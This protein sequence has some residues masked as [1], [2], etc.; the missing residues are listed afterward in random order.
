MAGGERLR[1]QALFRPEAEAL[2]DFLLYMIVTACIYSAPVIGLVFL[3]RRRIQRRIAS[4]LL[5]LAFACATAFSLWRMEWFDVW[6][7]GVPPVSYML[8]A[9]SP[10]LTVFGVLGWITGSLIVRRSQLTTRES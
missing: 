8:A 5:A 3:T 2:L 7:H 10:W 9:Y 4:G 1:I 6:R